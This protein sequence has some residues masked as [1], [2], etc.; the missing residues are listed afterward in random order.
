MQPHYLHALSPMDG[1]YHKK[2]DALRPFLSEYGLI[3]HRLIVEVQWLKTLAASDQIKDIPPLSVDAAQFLTD[4]CEQFD[5]KDALAIKR[6]EQTTH[7]DVKAVEY[8]LKQKM[9]THEALRPLVEIV[10]FA[11]TSEDINNIAYALMLKKARHVI[12]TSMQ[13]L[14]DRFSQFAKQY[15]DQPML[16]RTHG[17][18][19]SPTTV[20]KEYANIAHR[21]AI[22]ARQFQSVDLQAKLNGAVG[23]YN[24]HHVAYPQVHWQTLTI[25]LLN[26]FE[27]T[28]NPFTT[29]IEP[30]DAIAAYGHALMRFNT[31]LIDACRDI[32]GYIALNYFVQ[33]TKPGEV[34]S[35]T[36]PHKVNPIDFENA[37]GNLGVSNAMASHLSDQLPISRWQRDLSDSTALRHLGFVMG[38]SFIAYQATAQGLDK[39]V[40]NAQALEDDLAC[41]WEVLAEPIQTVMRRYRQPNAYEQ[42]KQFTRGKPIDQKSLHDFIR[43]THLPDTAKQALLKLTPRDYIGY[44]TKQAR[45]FSP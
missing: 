36:M 40:L 12:H 45:A 5:E 44:A 39:I 33:R 9:E 34:G 32:W 6:I 16:A 7:H 42:L 30:H 37:E 38:H 1:R 27:L 25:D 24:A 20:G 26:T 21:L 11:C 15:A 28:C 43:Q 10:H 8:F 4:L 13:T 2:V 31:V 35:S 23:N 14:I 41:H 29:Q 18:A 19:A 17:Q 22:Q 3:H